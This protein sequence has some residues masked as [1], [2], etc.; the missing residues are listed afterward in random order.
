MRGRASWQKVWEACK[1]DKTSG[2][3]TNPCQSQPWSSNR[4]QRV[5]PHLSQEDE[6]LTAP[7]LCPRHFHYFTFI[8]PH[9]H[10]KA[11]RNGVLPLHR[12]ENRNLKTGH[13]QGHKG[14]ALEFHPG[15]GIF[16]HQKKELETKTAGTGVG[17]PFCDQDRQL[18]WE[19]RAVG[20]SLVSCRGSISK[21]PTPHSK[22]PCS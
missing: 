11:R 8:L 6:R 15:R 10:Q 2:K 21:L 14:I 4:V 18:A 17:F 9:Y 12:R 1:T 16:S 19:G 22:Y 5:S 13:C 3:R 7:K 20:Q